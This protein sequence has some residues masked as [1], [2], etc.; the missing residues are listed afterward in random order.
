MLREPW[1]AVT[2]AAEAHAEGVAGPPKQSPTSHGD[3][4]PRQSC[5]F[6]QGFRVESSKS[7][8]SLADGKSF[9]SCADRPSG[10]A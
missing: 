10:P 4:L 9:P 5:G 8:L 3:N 6:R 1:K 7:H 2:Q